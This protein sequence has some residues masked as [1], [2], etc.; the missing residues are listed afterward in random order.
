MALAALFSRL[1]QAPISEMQLGNITTVLQKINF[2]A[3]VVDHGVREG[4]DI[5]ASQVSNVLS[6]HGT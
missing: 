6:Q 5:E 4:S 1:K 2:H 3:L